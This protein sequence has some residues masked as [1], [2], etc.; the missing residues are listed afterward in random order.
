MQI[1]SYEREAII[2][3]CSTHL[4]QSILYAAINNPR[5]IRCLFKKT[6]YFIIEIV[7]PDYVTTKKV[8]L[9]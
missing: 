3:L 1:E 8:F 9:K 5:K 4:H 6:G 7:T 2:A